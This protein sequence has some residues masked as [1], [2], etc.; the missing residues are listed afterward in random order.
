MHL[1][2]KQAATKC[3]SGQTY[4]A[5]SEQR[6]VDVGSLLQHLSRRFSVLQA[7]A[8]RQ[9]YKADLAKLWDAVIMI[10]RTGRHG[11]NVHRHDAV[12]ARGL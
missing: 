10:I 4:L 8:S 6:L 12:T 1:A 7:L 3:E 9:I 2:A 5:K 11:V